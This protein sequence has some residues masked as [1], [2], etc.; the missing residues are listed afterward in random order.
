MS[1]EQPDTREN[2]R[3]LIRTIIAGQCFAAPLPQVLINGGVFSLLIILLG[4]SKFEVGM[5]F[6]IQF[7][8]Q[9]TRVFAARHVDVR[10]RKWMVIRWALISNI[11]FLLIFTIE[12]IRVNL[13]N[14]VAMWAAIGVF[15][16]QRLA[17]H[18][19]MTAFNPMIA[20]FLPAPLR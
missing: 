18:R 3:G 14:R 15:F 7:V 20:Y 1:N 4:G 19:G 9:I 16:L 8:S 10:N 2:L 6:T 13:G 12:P 5:V 11:L 17:I